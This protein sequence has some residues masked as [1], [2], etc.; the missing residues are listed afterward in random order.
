LY[1]EATI[2]G[3]FDQRGDALGGLKYRTLRLIFT[4]AVPISAQRA[5]RCF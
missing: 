4:T 3:V 2:A 1:I 5:N